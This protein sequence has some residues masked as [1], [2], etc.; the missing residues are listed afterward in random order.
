MSTLIFKR[1]GQTL[2]SLTLSKNYRHHIW[3]IEGVK[4]M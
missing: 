4:I 3:D 2:E 1:V